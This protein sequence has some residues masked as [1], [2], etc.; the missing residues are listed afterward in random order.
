MLRP[1]VGSRRARDTDAG[2]KD[3]EGRVFYVRGCHWNDF[4]GD[5]AHYW[6][7][8]L[9]VDYLVARGRAVAGAPG[10]G[11][12]GAPGHAYVV[13]EVNGVAFVAAVGHD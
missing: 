10:H 7:A 11:G 8:H 3:W 9:L 1:S 12:A 2:R 5:V 4:V 6:S 13:A